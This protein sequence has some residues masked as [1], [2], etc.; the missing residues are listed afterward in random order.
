VVANSETMLPN[1]YPNLASKFPKGQLTKLNP[2]KRTQRRPSNLRE[3][4]ILGIL[5]GE[6]AASVVHIASTF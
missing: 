4:A 5:A 2:P 6:C 1:D 3:D